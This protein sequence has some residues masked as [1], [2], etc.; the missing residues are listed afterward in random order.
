M[1]IQLTLEQNGLKMQDSIIGRLFFNKYIVGPPQ[2][3]VLHPWI[4]PTETGNFCLPWVEP[5]N[6]KPA[7]AEG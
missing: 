1:N 5:Q 7:D 2:F 4:K 6:E 3:R